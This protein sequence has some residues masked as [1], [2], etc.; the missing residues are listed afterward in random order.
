MNLKTREVKQTIEDFKNDGMSLIPEVEELMLE[1]SKLGVS[2]YQASSDDGCAFS[3]LP[4]KGNSF[5]V[6]DS[7]GAG[8]EDYLHFKY[9]NSTKQW[10]DVKEH[11]AISKEGIN[12]KVEKALGIWI[13]NYEEYS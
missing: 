9:L 3:I 5:N 11:A 2:N 12:N 1:I 8:D 4:Q 13:N 6:T 10:F 7:Y